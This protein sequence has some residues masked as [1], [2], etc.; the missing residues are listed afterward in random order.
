[1]KFSALMTAASLSILSSSAAGAQTIDT[2]AT[3]ITLGE[4]IRLAQQNSVTTVQARGTIRTSEA[5]VKQS[6][7]A[8]LPSFSVSASRQKQSGDR[9]DTQG[10]L[11]PFTGQPTNYSTGLSSSLQLFDGG[12][13]F[14]DVKRSKADVDA[15]EAGETASRFNV[16]LQV[17]QQYYN[18]LAARESKSAADAQIQQAEQQLKSSSIRLRAGAATVSDSLRSVVALGN[19]RLALLTA[20]NNLR[21]ANATLTR[22]VASP[23]TVTAVASDTVDQPVAIPDIAAL[24]PLVNRAPAIQQADAQLASAHASVRSAKTAFLPTINMNFN[25]SGSGLDPQFGIGDKRY[26]YNQN[27][28]FSLNFPLFNNLNREVNVARAIVAEDVAEVQLRDAKMLAHQTLVQSVAQMKTAQEQV[29]IQ[30]VSV[31]AATED[32]RVQQRRYELG[33]TTLL[34]LHTSQT[35]LDNAR[36]ALIRARYDYRV[37]KAQLEALIG[38]DL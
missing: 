11:V 12:R 14:F 27:L 5:A 26:A 20:E 36:T 6:Y 30:T 8:F 24:E 1:M 18:I 28:S 25:R 35:A 15:A 32:L 3:P 22:L 17:K 34:D 16:S 2:T 4:A 13:R 37:A 21:V 10:N 7:A 38:R 31:A 9:F 29:A 23:T 33:A 19:A